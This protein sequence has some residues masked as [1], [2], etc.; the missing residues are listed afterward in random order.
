MGGATTDPVSVP[1]HR[2]RRLN[3]M[4]ARGTLVERQTR[5]IG[6]GT[7][8]ALP[9]VRNDDP[10]NAFNYGADVAD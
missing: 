1:S 2:A 7:Q 4:S 6:K 9:L 10:N 8:I 3:S 5:L